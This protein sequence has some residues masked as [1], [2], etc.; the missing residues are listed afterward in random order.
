MDPALAIN[1]ETMSAC[2]IRLRK[3][4]ARSVDHFEA[5]ELVKR[6]PGIDGRA[7]ASSRDGTRASSPSIL[8][9]IV[10]DARMCA[11]ELPCHRECRR[12]AQFVS[13]PRSPEQFLDD[14]PL[15]ESFVHKS[16]VRMRSVDRCQMAADVSN[17]K[18]FEPNQAADAHGEDLRG[19]SRSGKRASSPSILRSIVEEAR[20][21]AERPPSRPA[22][23]R[24]SR[25][26]SRP[27]SSGV[28]HESES[29]H[30]PPWSPQNTCM[31]RH[32]SA[33][34]SISSLTS[35]H[36]GGLD[37]PSRVAWPPSTSSCRSASKEECTG[38]KS[39]SLMRMM[40]EAA[41]RIVARSPSPIR[42]GKSRATQS[43]C[44][45]ARE[46]RSSARE[47]HKDAP[48]PPPPPFCQPSPPQE[49]PP[50]QHG[51]FSAFRD[52]PKQRR[53][54]SPRPPPLP[55]AR[56]PASPFEH[57]SPSS[58]SQ[59]KQAQ[60]SL[61]SLKK[62]QPQCSSTPV[63]NTGPRVD[64]PRPC[65]SARG[66]SRP[67]PTPPP[68]RQPPLPEEPP[69]CGAYFS[70][71]RKVVAERPKRISS[72]QRPLSPLKR[73]QSPQCVEEQAN[74]ARTSS[75]SQRSNHSISC[76]SVSAKPPLPVS[77]GAHEPFQRYAPRAC[78]KHDVKR[79]KSVALSVF[80]LESTATSE[81][82]RRAYKQAALQWHPDRPHNRDCKDEAKRRFQEVQESFEF[83]QRSF[84]FH[85][86]AVAGGC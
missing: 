30:M 13:Q 77:R 11:A 48:Q 73:P 58:P 34:S 44:L 18:S 84:T 40:A 55:E 70:E 56:P 45:S 57:G 54:M 31:R 3:A 19:N 47:A 53:F 14:G 22:A 66:S 81:E 6:L 5:P 75:L 4:R 17:M 86:L 42:C 60:Q 82:V 36:N 69:S 79:S 9:S 39:P 78:S 21:F 24:P 27:A 74:I 26:W 63:F 1:R 8:R 80:G 46:A 71:L 32:S 83:L 41:C 68:S 65:S 76:A 16:R 61:C 51:Y 2:S 43:R 52:A 72:P 15:Q 50:Q 38:K 20:N 49:P 62:E 7:R 35:D 10:E 59:S 67:P 37:V 29:L 64:T 28:A 25:A 12:H 23:R 85:A 33:P